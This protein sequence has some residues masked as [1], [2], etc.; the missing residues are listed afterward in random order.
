MEEKELSELITRLEWKISRQQY[1]L[2]Y[3]R[4]VHQ[5][6]RDETMLKL[7]VANKRIGK[8]ERLLRKNGIEL[9]KR[10]RRNF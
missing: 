5:K 4:E 8:L 10:Q 9:S 2:T 6:E 3:T 1:L 7:R